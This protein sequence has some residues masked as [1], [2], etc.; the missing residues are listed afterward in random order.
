VLKKLFAGLKKTRDKLAS[1]LRLGRVIDEESLDELEETLLAADVGPVTV[2]ELVEELRERFH[3]RE[4]ETTDQV[5]PYLHRELVRRLERDDAAPRTSPAPPLCILVAGV[6]GSGKTT[7]IAKLAWWHRQQG[8][9]VIL[10]A[11][12]TWRAAATEQL[13]IWAERLGCDIVKAGHGHDPAA[14]AFDAAAA[15]EARGHDVL[16]V[17]TAGRLHTE[18]NLMREL[19]KIHRVLG[20]KLPGAPHEVLLVLDA[21]FGQNALSQSERF[22]SAVQVTGVFLAKLD[23][24]ARGGV[25]VEIQRRFGI[26]IKFVGLGETAE[27]LELFDPEKFVSGLLGTEDVASMEV[28]P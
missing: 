28:R 6:N 19:E 3:A 21:N 8:R 18:T 10:A 13:T 11:S 17:D 15:A 25:A 14:V 4:I 27:D 23:G 24:T 20:R 7:S 12:D 5:R 9:S 16:I 26:P 1:V 2:D 22:S